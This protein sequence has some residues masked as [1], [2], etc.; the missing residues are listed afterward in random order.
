[1]NWR[2]LAEAL[3]AHLAE[4]AAHPP[5]DMGAVNWADLH[6]VDIKERR[7]LLEPGEPPDILVRVEE[8]E[9]LEL[10]RHLN[11]W[12]RERHPDRDDISAVTEW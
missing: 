2:E 4:L 12:L 7:S 1:M 8:A 9:S 5:E 10:E 3:D 11:A 6:V